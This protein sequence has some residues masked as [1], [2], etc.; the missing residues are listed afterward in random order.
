MAAKTVQSQWRAK[1][2][3]FNSLCQSAA[4]LRIYFAKVCKIGEIT[5]QKRSQFL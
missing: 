2:N 5:K 1:V 4:N 3:S